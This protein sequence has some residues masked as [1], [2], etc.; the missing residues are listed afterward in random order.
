MPEERFEPRHLRVVA[1][2]RRTDSVWLFSFAAR[3][4]ETL[5]DLAFEPGQIAVLS[6]PD[7]GDAYMAIA[8]PPGSGSTLE[9]LVKRTGDVGAL[10][11]DLGR[12]ADVRLVA[13]T[14]RGFPVDRFEGKDL[15][16][17]AAGTAIAPVRSALSHACTR[18]TSFGR[19][20]LIHGVRRPEDFAVDDELDRWRACDVD[21]RLT[22]S[23]PGQ[24]S[25]AGEVGRVQRLLETA[26]RDTLDPVAFVVGSDE[27]MAETTE[28]LEALGLPR[29]RILRNY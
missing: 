18:R 13:I 19:I 12:D 6:L 9:F 29:E 2:A 25:W 22:V 26:V 21:V 24:A 1:A 27:M 15:V 4:G 23:Q 5:A 28:A 7:A 14:G 10:L 3:D 8:S 16:F 17:V 11:C 20:V